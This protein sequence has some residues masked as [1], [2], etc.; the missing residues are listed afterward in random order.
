MKKAIAILLA[1]S[2]LLVSV[3]AQAQ[4]KWFF[5]HLGVGVS[6]GLDGIGADIVLPCTPFIQIRGG[7]ATLPKQYVSYDIATTRVDLV[8]ANGDVWD[9]HQDVTATASANL[10]AAH[11]FLDFYL[12]K[13]SG[14]HL[15]VG[16]YYGLH[17]ENGGPYRV[18]T[19]EPLEIGDDKGSLG[20]ELKREDGTSE[21]ITTDNE[22]YLNLDY[23][24]A[25]PLG[26]KIGVPNLYPYAGI[27]FGRNLSKNR[28]ALSMDLG[29]IYTGGI[30]LKSYNYMYYDETKEDL[31]IK[32]TVIH[33]SDIEGLKGIDNG[34]YDEYLDM[35]A[36]YYGMAESIPVT[37]IL[38]FNLVFRIF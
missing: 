1:A 22:G 17:P 36:K 25:N 10:D 4:D 5:N 34:N 16:G 13:R 32:E 2:A 20:I 35:A 12:G 38:K 18:G 24:L 15:T 30:N 27:G 8:K 23:N 7:Y 26:E 14:L 6:A 37:P 21:Y 28:I 9:L 29:V 3:S 31:G 33:A 19:K 11:L